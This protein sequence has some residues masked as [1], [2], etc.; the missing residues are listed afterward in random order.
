[1]L[2][3]VDHGNKQI[4]TAHGEPFVSGLQQSLTRPFGQSLQYCG[5]YYTLSN[6]RIP[7]HKDKTEDDRF[8]VLTLIAIAE[9][10][11]AR[12]LSEK[13]QQIHCLFSRPRAC[14]VY[15]W[16]QTLYHQHRGC[17]L[18]SP[19]I[20]SCGYNAA[21]PVGRSKGGRIG[22]WRL[23][24]GLSVAEKRKSRPRLLRFAGKRRYPVIQ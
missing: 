5:T 17:G 18:L 3:G 14:S 13:E 22:Y 4:K 7:F 15:V 21:C 20:R 19:G 12:G 9:E 8:F 16:G 2:I 11:T 10:I 6:E 23:H 1:M 24:G